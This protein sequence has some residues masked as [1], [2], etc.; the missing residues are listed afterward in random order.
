MRSQVRRPA[1]SNP[2]RLVRRPR[3]WFAATHSG[4]FRDPPW[5]YYGPCARS[6]LTA[7]VHRGDTQAR[8]EA[9]AWP[10]GDAESRKWSAAR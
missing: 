9:E 5:G 8:T 4:G 7:P 2:Q 1:R 3:A 6:S 10:Q